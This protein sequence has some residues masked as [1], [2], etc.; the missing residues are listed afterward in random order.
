MLIV[1][2]AVGLAALLLLAVLGYGLFGHLKRLRQAV[3]DAQTAVRPELEEL[4]VG[5]RRAQSLRMQDAERDAAD[6]TRG[7][8]RHA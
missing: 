3:A 4:T 5:I 6:A 1:W 8:E 2:L 7:H